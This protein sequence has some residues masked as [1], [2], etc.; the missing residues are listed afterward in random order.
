MARPGFRPSPLAPSLGGQK[1]RPRQSNTS[2]VREQSLPLQLWPIR[3][4]PGSQVA[5]CPPVPIA[6]EPTCLCHPGSGTPA[7]AA[8]PLGGLCPNLGPPSPDSP[9]LPPEAGDGLPRPHPLTRDDHVSLAPQCGFQT[10]QGPGLPPWHCGIWFPPLVP[11]CQ[12]GMAPSGSMWVSGVAL[13][14]E[15]LGLG[16]GYTCKGAPGTGY[17]RLCTEIHSSAD[18]VNPVGRWGERQHCR[19]PP[20][21]CARSRVGDLEWAQGERERVR[22]GRQVRF[23][24]P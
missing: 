10:L 24:A 19:L 3:P 13:C 15:G 18:Q 23:S 17:T 8:V 2:P 9:R 22:W 5:L 1:T 4:I 21:G 7:G 16:R 20:L 11:G 6:P 14:R 12:G